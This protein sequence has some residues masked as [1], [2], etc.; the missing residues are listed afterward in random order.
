MGDFSGDAPVLRL[1]QVALQLG[2]RPVLREVSLDLRA[3]EFVG[4]IGANGAGKTT[5]LRVIL[6]LLRPDSGSV[7]VLGRPL[8]RGNAAV[9]YVPQKQHLDPETPL[10]GRD[11]VALGI[12]GHRWGIPLPSAKR[13]ARVDEALR[14]V[15]AMSYAN[16]PVGKLSGGEQQRLLI[17]Q[18]LLAD[19]KILLLDEPLSN[20]DIRGA[21]EVVRLVARIGRE[22]N[23]AVLLVAHDMNPLMEVMNRVLYLAEGRAA[24]GPVD[25]VVRTEVLS[26]LY[27]YPVDVLH[28]RG[29]ILVLGGSE[30][31][32]GGRAEHEVH[33]HD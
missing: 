28:V 7:E 16:A 29:R 33:A 4:L 6:G 3:G 13:K 11:L 30:V 18:A 27:G 1:N 24:V 22:R 25:T 26:R 32:M 12:D 9:G 8:R 31:L 15:D 20:L 23:V 10:R 17:A 2:G 19:P 21:N 14:A 5:L